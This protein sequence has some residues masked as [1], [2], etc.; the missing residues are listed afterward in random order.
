LHG[1]YRSPTGRNVSFCLRRY[2]C[3][4][5]DLLS[6]RSFSHIISHFMSASHTEGHR[7]I[8]SLFSECLLLRDGS[9]HLPSCQTAFH[10]LT[11]T[12]LLCRPYLCMT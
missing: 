1:R 11:L 9:L 10:V 7:A 3:D 8:V 12:T 2:N 4:F 6:C 5:N